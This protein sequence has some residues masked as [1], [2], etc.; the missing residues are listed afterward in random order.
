MPGRRASATRIAVSAPEPRDVASHATRQDDE[1]RGALRVVEAE[2]GVDRR[3]R[4]LLVQLVA[5]VAV[6]RRRAGQGAGVREPGRAAVGDG[7]GRAGAGDRLRGR[8]PARG[9]EPLGLRAP[10][11]GV[12]LGHGDRLLARGVEVVA[13]EEA[14]RGGGVARAL[15]V[16][17][18]LQR[19][20]ARQRAVEGTA[21]P[22]SPSGSRSRGAR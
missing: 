12:A 10:V 19:D 18:R 4:G 1:R 7:H 9:V 13:L 11:G 17:G 14:E 20:D 5:A 6:G 2:S 8:L 16:G 15:Q 22:G 21:P 3:E